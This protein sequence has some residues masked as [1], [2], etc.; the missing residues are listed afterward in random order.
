[1]PFRKDDTICRE[2][3]QRFTGTHRPSFQNWWIIG[4][5]IAALLAGAAFLTWIGMN[6]WLMIICLVLAYAILANV[7]TD[8][9]G[10]GKSLCPSCKSEKFIKINSP[11][12]QQLKREWDERK[13][14][15]KRNVYGG[16]PRKT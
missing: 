12:G 3:G 2:C 5:K 14:S 13:Q 1:M 8:T 16:K 10:Y 11:L 15:S 6:E 7:W 9:D 4:G